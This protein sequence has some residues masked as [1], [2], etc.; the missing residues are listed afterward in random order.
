MAGPDRHQHR[1]ADLLEVAHLLDVPDGEALAILDAARDRPPSR[2]SSQQDS[3]LEG[4][5]VVFTGNMT[6]S[7]SEIE[8]L[9]TAADLW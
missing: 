2:P 4:D 1:P 3:L 9:A 5:W 8:E 6:M 7:R